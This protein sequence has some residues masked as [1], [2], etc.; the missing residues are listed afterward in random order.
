M[1]AL[2]ARDA[3]ASSSLRMA[4]VRDDDGS[5]CVANS[6]ARQSLARSDGDF[7]RSLASRRGAHEHISLSVT[8]DF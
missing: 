7:T 4:R 5:G 6:R 1:A 8:D 2:G 3:L